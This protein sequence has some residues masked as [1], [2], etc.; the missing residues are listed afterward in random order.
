MKTARVITVIIQ[1]NAFAN[2]LNT[3][4]D[5]FSLY[6]QQFK[7]NCVI[8]TN[9]FQLILQILHNTNIYNFNS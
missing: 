3:N 8:L 1:A 6:V 7:A 2:C 9:Q 4:S 5:A